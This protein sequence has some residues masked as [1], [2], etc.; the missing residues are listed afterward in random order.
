M[1]NLAELG[2]EFSQNLLSDESSWCLSLDESELE[3]LPEFVIN[4][5]S[6]AAL[7]RDVKGY[8]LTLSRSILEPFLQFSSNRKL[9]E[10]ASPSLE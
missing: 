3:G 8:A 5:M 4:S 2:T 10:K 7:D 6:Q 9:R 1:Q